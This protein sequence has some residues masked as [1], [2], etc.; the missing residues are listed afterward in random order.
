MKLEMKNQLKKNKN[1]FCVMAIIAWFLSFYIINIS[2]ELKYSKLIVIFILCII[3]LFTDYIIIK[4]YKKNKKINYKKIITSL[5]IIGIIL[6]TCYILYTPITARQHDM[7]NE[8]GHLAY[9]E[10]I[11]ETGRLPNHNKWQFYQQPL[12]HIIASMWLKINSAL[13]VDLNVAE[14]GIQILTAIYSSLII[15]ITYCILREMNIKDKYKMLVIAII[16]V[17]PTFIILSGSINNDILMIMFTFFD[18][19]YLV[20]WYKDPSIKHTLILALSVALGALTKIS[21]TIIAVPIIYIFIKRFMEEYNY[22]EEYLKILKKYAIKFS[23]FGIIALGIGLSFS[24]RNLIRFKQ[25]I[26]YVP[27]P[28]QFVYCGYRTWFD[29]LNPFSSEWANV[30]CYADKDCNIFSYLV[31]CSLFGE[32]SYNENLNTLIERL[33]IICNIILILIS[34]TSLI[35]IIIKK[36]K[37]STLNNIFIIFYITQ[38]AMYIYGNISMPYGCTMDF[39]YIVQTILMGMT[40]IV[41]DLEQNKNKKYKLSVICVLSLFIVLSMIFELTDMS[42]LS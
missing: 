18:F 16:A 28:G 40:F 35:K 3:F 21:S 39:R 20:K 42:I 22:S 2:M 23:V 29:R 19:L 34:I 13:G 7:E 30:F 41:N 9:I 11:Y 33:L 6:R 17:H 10:T 26:F 4:E 37:S 38:I 25:S 24:I 31:K 1:L 15:I 14:E 32:Y 36:R 27:T 12:H 8:V 5:S